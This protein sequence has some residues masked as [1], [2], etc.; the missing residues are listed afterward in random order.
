MRG[1]ALHA[2]AELNGNNNGLRAFL[3]NF[4]EVCKITDSNLAR[5]VKVAA[6]TR[7]SFVVRSMPFPLH[8]VL[9]SI[10]KRLYNHD[11]FFILQSVLF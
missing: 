1:T 4:G 8:T 5:N 3:Y 9:S 11:R 10:Y 7:T 6:G 2:T